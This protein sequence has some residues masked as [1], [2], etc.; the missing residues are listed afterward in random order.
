MQVTHLFH[1]F[2]VCWNLLFD[3][4]ATSRCSHKIIYYTPE[5]KASYFGFIG[6]VVKSFNN[7][8]QEVPMSGKKIESYFHLLL[9]VLIFQ[10]ELLFCR[11]LF[12]RNGW[13]RLVPVG[14]VLFA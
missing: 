5:V 13:A 6:K 3:D 1:A 4:V 12:W 2:L 14:L 11:A 9:H 8:C 10:V 7:V